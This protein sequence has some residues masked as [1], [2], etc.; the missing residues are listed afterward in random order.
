M[1]ILIIVISIFFSC[2][3]KKLI[4]ETHN[5]TLPDPCFEMIKEIP[6]DEYFK[7]VT[8]IDTCD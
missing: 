8:Y 2:S 4:I 5:K 6:I 3:Y 1:R 7:E